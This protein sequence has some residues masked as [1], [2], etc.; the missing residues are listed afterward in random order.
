DDRAEL[1]C[2]GAGHAADAG[3]DLDQRALLVLG[4][5]DAERREVRRHLVVA[6]GHELGQRQLGT[7]LVVE[8]PAGLAHDVVAARHLLGDATRRLPRDQLT[9]PGHRAILPDAESDYPA[10]SFVTGVRG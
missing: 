4:G 8:H 9:P 2:E 3:T 10:W 1:T 7:G 6:G 5:A